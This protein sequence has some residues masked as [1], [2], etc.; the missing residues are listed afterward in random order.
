MF[1]IGPRDINLVSVKQGTTTEKLLETAIMNHDAYHKQNQN[2]LGE[3]H[4]LLTSIEGQDR[5]WYGLVE[6]HSVKGEQEQQKME[7]LLVSTQKTLGTVAER[8]DHLINLISKGRRTANESI[9]DPVSLDKT[10][11]IAAE[12]AFSTHQAQSVDKLPRLSE[13]LDL[14]LK[15]GRHPESFNKSNALTPYT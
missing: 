3:A 2:R 4:K 15:S 9:C 1:N 5:A 14:T 11:K 6:K 10:P 8:S 7:N 12:Q 13:Q